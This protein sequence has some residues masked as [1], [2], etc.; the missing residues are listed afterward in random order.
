MKTLV[1]IVVLLLLALYL[2]FGLTLVHV[3]LD[4]VGGPKEYKKVIKE[5]EGFKSDQT[6][7]LVYVI[8]IITLV[9]GWP[10]FIHKSLEE[11]DEQEDGN[12]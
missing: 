9:L 6:V 2:S 1:T 4:S 8:A 3:A 7:N 10:F 11:D 12:D 5:N